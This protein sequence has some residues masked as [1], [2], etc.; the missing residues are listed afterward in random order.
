M[1][2]AIVA[3]RQHVYTSILSHMHTDRADSYSL[4]ALVSLHSSVAAQY[5]A[6]I[7]IATAMIK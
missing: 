1:K 6:L 4:P 5:A 2:L 3:I 7:T